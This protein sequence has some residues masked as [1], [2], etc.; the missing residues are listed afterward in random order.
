LLA[1]K[2]IIQFSNQRIEFAMVS[3]DRNLLA[4][5]CAPH[6]RTCNR[7]ATLQR[8]IC[9]TW[10]HPAKAQNYGEE[11]SNAARHIHGK[12]CA[13]AHESTLRALLYAH[14]IDK[15]HL[16]VAM[17]EQEEIRTLCVRALNKQGL[18]RA[19]AISRLR[20]AIRNY[21]EDQSDEKFLAEVL[22]MPH[23]AV[24]IMD[25]KRAA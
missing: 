3:L 11:L 5:L 25:K 10:Y 20:V 8:I 2:Q 15:A 4:K 23:V 9:D 17:S 12:K 6:F 22:T 24:L 7:S 14:H 13:Q 18:S 21:L 1:L 19:L 16:K